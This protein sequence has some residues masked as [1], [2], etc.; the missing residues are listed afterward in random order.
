MKVEFYDP[1][2]GFAGAVIR[3]P[4]PLKEVADSLNGVTGTV[5]DAITLFQEAGDSL[6]A[7][8]RFGKVTVKRVD[9]L[10]TPAKDGGREPLGPPLDDPFISVWLTEGNGDDKKYPAHSFK[11]ICYKEVKHDDSLAVFSPD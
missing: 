4:Q 5:E 6:V 8:K 9:Q 11:A 2:P 3:F 1:H 7:Q 10:F